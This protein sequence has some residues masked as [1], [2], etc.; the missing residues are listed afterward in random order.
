MR[1]YSSENRP[2]P[3]N[4]TESREAAQPPD[5]SVLES[6][7]RQTLTSDDEPLTAAEMEALREVSRRHAGQ[8]F[9]LDPHGVAIVETLLSARLL[10]SG[11]TADVSAEVAREVATSLSEVP[12]VWG[13]V[14]QL[15]RRLSGTSL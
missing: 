10:A 6:V 11:V 7:L 8:P 13:R 1:E 14:E 15:W 5:P 3:E 2:Q 9:A 12:E 4:S